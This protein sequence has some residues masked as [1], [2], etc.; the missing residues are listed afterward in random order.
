MGRYLNAKARATA[1]LQRLEQQAVT[2]ERL[3]VLAHMGLRLSQAGVTYADITARR[4]EA[5]ANAGE[6]VHFDL[7]DALELLY[8][9]TFGA[10]T[11]GGGR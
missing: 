10:A 1:T 7:N 5:N 6:G 8:D 9:E 4:N 11:M 3:D 2:L